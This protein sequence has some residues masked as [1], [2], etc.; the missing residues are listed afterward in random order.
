MLI[1]C[2]HCGVRPH[3]EFTYGGDA[4][5]GA[6]P[7]DAATDAAWM[8]FVYLRE[9]PCGAH[10]E[11]WHHTLGCESWSVVERDTLTHRISGSSLAGVERT[12]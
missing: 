6:R 5:V 7:D 4:S 2:P 1:P 11:H 12:P 9:N 3:A 10:R 8:Q